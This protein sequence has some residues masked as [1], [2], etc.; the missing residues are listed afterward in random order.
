M[1]AFRIT[2]GID[3]GQ[4]GAIAVLAD[5]GYEAF[6]DMPVM[7]RE[8]GGHHVNGAGLADALRE[9]FARHPGA[10]R[11]AV[12][13]Q[14]SAMPKQGSSSTFRFGEGYGVIRGVLGALGVPFITVHSSSWKRTMQL[15]GKDKDVA[16]TLAMQ[17]YP[18]AA[19]AL[20]RKKDIGRA[21]ALLIAAWAHQTEQV[22]KAA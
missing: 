21:D 11:L 2:L 12:M 3:P 7:P 22:G 4:T 9:V 18:A 10:A 20:S 15:Y 14:V 1:S 17:L 8:S 19:G 5:A 16:R 6:I 13:E